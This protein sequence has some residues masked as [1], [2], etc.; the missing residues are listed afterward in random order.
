MKLSVI[1]LYNL[2]PKK[3]CAKCGCKTCIGFAV[4]LIERKKAVEDCSYLEET[5]KNKLSELLKTP[6]KEII[7]GSGKSA[8]KIGGEQ[9]MYRHELRFFNPTLIALQIDD[10]MQ[11]AEIIERAKIV[12][13]RYIERMGAKQG[14]DMIALSLTDETKIRKVIELCKKYCN[15]PFLLRCK[16][17][18]IAKFAVSLVENPLIECGSYGNIQR[19]DTIEEIN[20]RSIIFFAGNNIAK[21]IEN[22]A[23]VREAAIKGNERFGWPLV[24]DATIAYELAEGKEAEFLEAIL[25]AMFILRYCSV[26]IVKNPE[27]WAHLPLITLR[28]AVYSNPRE[29]SKIKPGLYRIGTPNEKSPVFVT[30]NYLLTY[31]IVKNDMEKDNINA[32]LLVVDSDGYAVDSGIAA[33]TFTAEKIAAAIKNEKLENFVSHRNLIIPQLASKLSGAI[34]EATNWRV[35]IGT[36]DSS[37]IG[38]FLKN[39]IRL[40]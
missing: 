3:N 29:K 5:N 21:I 33:G 7:V 4:Q 36:R 14:I 20:G 9:V 22:C 19:V 16:N 40:Q 1:E 23:L 6:V 25:A 35:I 18:E 31:N 34:E 8:R 37:Q 32:Y 13:N 12:Q 38:S 2:L 28:Q 30:V 15:K 17:I 26:V 27:I 39:K 11:E 10:G 24:Q